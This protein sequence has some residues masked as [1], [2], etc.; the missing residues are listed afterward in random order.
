MNIYGYEELRRR[1]RAVDP[2]LDGKDERTKKE[3]SEPSIAIYIIGP[4]IYVILGLIAGRQAWFTYSTNT[5]FLRIERTLFAILLSPFY[6][7]YIFIKTYAHSLF[8]MA[9]GADLL[10]LFRKPYYMYNN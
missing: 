1:P 8:G 6:V 4:I 10:D 5:L 7:L 3:D 2:V 9:K